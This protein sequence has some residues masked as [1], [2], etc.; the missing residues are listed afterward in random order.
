MEFTDHAVQKFKILKRLGFSVSMEQVA[1][2]VDN[3]DRVDAGW[4]GRFIASSKLNRE[5]VLRVVYEKVDDRKLMV[6]FYPTRRERYEGQ[7]Q[8]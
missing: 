2:V 3:P 4:K 5:H 1:R 8:S 7:L 6:T